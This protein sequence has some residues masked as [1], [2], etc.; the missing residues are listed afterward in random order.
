MLTT[1]EGAVCRGRQRADLPGAMERT[2]RVPQTG[3]TSADPACSGSYARIR[4]SLLTRSL[5]RGTHHLKCSGTCSSPTTTHQHLP[6][7]PPQL[8][9]TLVQLTIQP[10]HRLGEVPHSPP[11]FKAIEHLDRPPHHLLQPPHTK[12]TRDRIRLPQHRGRP[13]SP[14]VPFVEI[15]IADLDRR[16]EVKVVLL[17]RERSTEQ[18]RESTCE[19]VSEEEGGRGAS[20]RSLPMRA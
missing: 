3:G 6:T 8:E 18:C 20:V 15:D 5:F 7:F 13:R 17:Y 1:V 2:H 11:S 19:V 4:I 9:L 10:Q 14:H 16:R 12:R